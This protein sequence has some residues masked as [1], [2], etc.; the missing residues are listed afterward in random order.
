MNFKIEQD[1]IY[2][3]KLSTGEEIVC[4]VKEIN[5]STAIA[6]HPVS[7]VVSQQGLQMMPSMFS[8]N[9]D[10]TVQ[11]SLANIVLV[12]D[13]REDVKSSYL[14]ATTGIQ[15]PPAKQIITG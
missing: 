10:N 13:T 3:F 8:S 6:V 1:E 15:T 4:R 9:L 7:C 5:E 14:Q 2:T 11:I 12:G